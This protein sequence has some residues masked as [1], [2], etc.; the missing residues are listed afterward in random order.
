MTDPTQEFCSL[1]AL[2]AE[3]QFMIFRALPDLSTLRAF[4]L[5]N[6]ILYKS[7]INHASSISLDV[8]SNE[9]P[10][11]ILPEAI[12]AWSSSRIKPWSKPRVREFLEDYH[13][14]RE[15]QI[16]QSWTHSNAFEIS[17]LY[18]RCRFFASEMIASN[19]SMNS[20]FG[21]SS[22]DCPPSSREARRFERTFFRFELYCNLFRKQSPTQ[23]RT[24]R[25]DGIE[26]EEIYF[27][28]YA[29]WENDQLACVHDYLY[30]QLS[31]SFNDFALHDV[32]WGEQMVSFLFDDQAPENYCKE[33]ILS[34]GLTFLQ[35]LVA[36]KTYGQRCQLLRHNLKSDDLFLWEGLVARGKE[37][38]RPIFEFLA[39]DPRVVINQPFFQDDDDEGP[40][41][42]WRWAYENWV[43]SLLC[44]AADMYDLRAWGFCLWDHA[45]LLSWGVFNKACR[46]RP[47]KGYHDY[48]LTAQKISYE[49]LS[50]SREKRSKIWN[51]GGRG[52]WE[53]GDE[54]KIVWDRFK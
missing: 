38:G 28:H 47:L 6:S 40:E 8:L 26:Q 54:S 43:R 45:R 52:W 37:A 2:P 27:Q 29:Y 10:Y 23:E 22:S 18:Q 14:N 48:V 35:H 7:F 39:E 13:A 36:A 42:A 53:D 44:I 49:K 9:I 16:C 51:Q 12:V 50:K 41:K 4:I 46:D 20:V 34:L 3:I 21:S 33:Y 19:L 1:L 31:I 32:E 15:A 24:E 30:R 5:T 11:T 25:F 17:K